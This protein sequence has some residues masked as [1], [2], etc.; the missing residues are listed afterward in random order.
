GLSFVILI[1][2]LGH[3][4]VAKW[5]GVKVKAFALGLGPIVWGFRIGETVY[6]IAPFPLGGYVSMLGE[7]PGE[8][9]DKD[10]DPGAYP[11]KSVGAR[12]AIISA[13]VVM[14]LICGLLFF[15]IAYHHGGLQETPAKI[16]SVVAGMPA[17]EAGIRTGD[18]IVALDGRRE[19]SFEDL[20]R[21]VA[22]S[23]S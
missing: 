4:L 6:G 17:Y 19:V 18:E 12:M 14:N 22:L 15:I 10:A 13:G 5:Y 21:T 9:P 23:G 16:G 2:E 20:L 8:D 11:N 3:F 1:H 7:T